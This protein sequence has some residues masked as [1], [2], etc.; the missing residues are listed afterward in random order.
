MMKV[1]GNERLNHEP[2]KYIM[3]F[4]RW[5]C[6]PD[7]LHF[8]EGDLYELYNERMSRLGKRRADFR[9][10]IDVLLLLRPGI[11]RQLPTYHNQNN[12][13]MLKNYLLIAFRSIRL[14]KSY[15]AINIS[16]LAIGM[17]A[18]LLI[19]LYVSDELKYDRHH[20]DLDRLYRIASETSSEKWVAAPAPMA[21]ALTKD[22]PE[23]EESTRLLRF[24]GAENMLVKDEK[25]ENQFIE[26]QAYYVDATFFTIFSF[27]FIHGNAATALT[28]PNTI[29]LAEST[30]QKYFGDED[31]IGKTLNIGLSFGNLNYTVKGVFRDKDVK[32]HIPAKLLLSMNNNDVGAW[33]K[34][35]TAWASNSIFHTYVKLRPGTDVNHFESKLDDFLNN[36]GGEEFK[37][38]GFEKHLF[39][40]PVKDIYL[41]SNYGYEIAS[42]GNIK[43]LFVLGSIASFLLIIACINFMNLSTARS[44]RRARE[45]GLRR[46]N[47]ARIGGFL[48]SWSSRW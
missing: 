24:P 28:E 15:S 14:N 16:G 4:F 39:I 25:G 44:E 9:F 36:H 26:S 27:D 1:P 12:L 13:D 19:V 11:V 40:Q 10:V 34:T 48:N 21:E 42:N 37:A 29:V 22:F 33:V 3:Q 20:V 32:S 35:Q 31:P 38:A 43:N 18:C 7:L 47:G 2:P 45:V 8:I 30:A 17:A 41:H 23:V 6:H 5:F 46:V